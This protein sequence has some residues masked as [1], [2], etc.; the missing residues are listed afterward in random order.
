MLSNDILRS[1]RYTLKVN[2]NDMV[3]ILAL[4]DMES[5]SASFDTGRRKRM[6]RA[7]SAA[8]TLSCRVSSTALSMTSA[9]KTIRR[10]SW[11]W[12]AG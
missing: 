12:S 2:N 5:T 1:L 7:L 11:R 9:V 3:R 10:R 6:K 4:S 8:R